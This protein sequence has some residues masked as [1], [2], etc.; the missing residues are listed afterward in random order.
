MTNDPLIVD[1][2]GRF[3]YEGVT[4]RIVADTLPTIPA[5]ARMPDDM[6][7]GQIFD[8]VKHNLELFVQCLLDDREH[9]DAELAVLR[10]SATQRGREGLPLQ[11]MLHGYRLGARVAWLSLIDTANSD[12]E[13]R[14]L[15]DVAGRIMKYV[16]G[17]STAVAQAYLDEREQLVS[18]QERSARALMDGLLDATAGAAELQ[19][20][21][22]ITGFTLAERYR[23]FAIS[24]PARPRASTPG[25]R[26]SCAPAAAWRS[27][28]E[29]GS[30]A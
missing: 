22:D 3:D 14:A 12:A 16:D 1:L 13:H 5:Y 15:L 7:S 25:S 8:I 28:R 21:A 29:T 6:M 19:R 11:D 2:I 17:V 26:S 18:E 24:A 23:P 30:A 27:P 10:A 20:L 4:R 9:N